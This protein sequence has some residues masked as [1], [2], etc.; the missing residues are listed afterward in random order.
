M[1][2][3]LDKALAHFRSTQSSF[4][5]EAGAAI[6]KGNW[7]SLESLIDKV[8]KSK[9]VESISSLVNSSGEALKALQAKFNPDAFKFISGIMIVGVGG[10]ILAEVAGVAAAIGLSVMSTYVIGCLLLLWGVS[11]AF[12][13][14]WSMALEKLKNSQNDWLKSF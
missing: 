4:I 7:N 8:S 6:S 1:N 10:G 3:E 2:S 5:I 14:V 9:V 11:L 12:P 13:S